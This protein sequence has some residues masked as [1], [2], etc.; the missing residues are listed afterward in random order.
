MK[1]N[2]QARQIY[3]DDKVRAIEKAWKDLDLPVGGKGTPIVDDLPGHNPGI[4][5]E[6]RL[7]REIAR[8]ATFEVIEEL[9]GQ[10][11]NYSFDTINDMFGS[12]LVADYYEWKILK[13]VNG[14]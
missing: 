10:E 9:M 4:T 5:E 1:D 8:Q 2:W 12:K 3:E 11:F 6:Q 14:T 7:D 13:D